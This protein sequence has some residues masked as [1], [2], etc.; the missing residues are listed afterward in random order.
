MPAIHRS[1]GVTSSERR[2]QQLCQR[3]FLSLWSYSS[4]FRD[5]GRKNGIG[6]GKE[7][8]DLLVVFDNHIIIFS[9]KEC[10]FPNTG[11]LQ[12]DW[13]R[14]FRKSIYSSAEQIWGAERRLREHADLIYLDAKCT[15]PFPYELRFSENT[16][17][18]RVAVAHGASKRCK[19]YFGGSGSLL[20]NTLLKGKSQHTEAREL[21]NVFS[22][23]IL[24]EAKGFVH[25]LDDTT[26]EL[27]LKTLDTITD[28]TDYLAAKEDIV[29]KYGIVAVGEEEL[30]AVY[31]RHQNVDKKHYFPVGD[32]HDFIAVDEGIWNDFNNSQ[33][34][35]SQ[36]AADEISYRW[37]E[38]IEVL[39][40]DILDDNLYSASHSSTSR[41]EEVVRWLAR[42]PRLTRRILG[43]SLD[44]IINRTSSVHRG[45]RIFKPLNGNE[46]RPY[47]I[48]LAHP[49]YRT[50]TSVN[51]REYREAFI[52][53][54]CLVVKYKFPTAKHVIGIA[55]EERGSKGRSYDVAYFN[56]DQ[57]NKEL[58]KQAEQFMDE[59]GL[60]DKGELFHYS[61]F[62]YPVSDDLLLGRNQKIRV[63]GNSRNLPCPCGSGKKYKHCCGCR[64]Q[65]F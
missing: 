22:V 21:P 63:K 29:S 40:K 18:H 54:C 35:V 41:H 15:V 14:W 38:M 26:L 12:L 19:Q 48:F 62:E 28:F 60:F 45:A 17:L 57:W 24:D 32:E 56:C 31:L 50:Q 10:D 36:I 42:E 1:L 11:D 3:T 39:N 61:A 25:V 16:K 9:D 37:D 34:R 4:V 13:S 49:P 8:C 58:Y 7:L 44:Y 43:Q 51:Y 46:E 65:N 47:Y 20:I 6:D 33:V 5:Q 64:R 2:L 55:T 27:V 23:G 59:E 53:N 52:L 30:L